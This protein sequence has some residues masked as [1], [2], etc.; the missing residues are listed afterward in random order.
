MSQLAFIVEAFA[1]QWPSVA[2]PSGAVW[3]NRHPWDATR[4]I[5]RTIHEI[6]SRPAPEATETVQYLSDGPALTYA[7]VA[8]HVLA[9]QHKAHRGF[10]YTAPSIDALRR[11]DGHPANRQARGRQTTGEPQGR[12]AEIGLAADAGR[13]VVV[14]HRPLGHCVAFPAHGAGVKP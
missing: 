9:L 2:R 11:L 6:A 13:E 14:A 5:E 3:G 7:H 1:P 12:R 8:R 4:F 10:E